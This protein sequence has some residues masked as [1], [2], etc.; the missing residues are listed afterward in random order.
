MRP[1]TRELAYAAARD[2]GN[3]AMR[4]AGRTIWDAEDY[5]HA[6]AE[7]DRLWPLER[8]MGH[9]TEEVKP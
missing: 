5:N 7:F 3:R 1:L 9:G 6:A 4:A 8:D 2:A